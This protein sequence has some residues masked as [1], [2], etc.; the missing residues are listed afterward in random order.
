VLSFIVPA[1]LFGIVGGVVV[2]H[3]P[4]RAVLVL[5]S[6]L[7]AL[8]CIVFLRSSESVW[9]I[10]GTNL[11]LST[12]SQFSGPAESAVVP[13]LV[14]GGQIA[15]ATALLNV[16]VILAQVAGTVVLAPLFVKTLG[17]DRLFLTTIVLFALSAAA[18]AAMPRSPRRPPGWMREH[19]E[20]RFTGLRASAVE[21]WRV[22][23]SNRSVFLAG[24]QQTVVTT[25]IVVLVSLLPNY[26]RSTLHLPTEDAVFV[27]APAAI[28]VGLGNWLVPKLA[29]RRGRSLLAGAG[30]LVFLL[31]L[32][33]LGFSV[34]VEDLAR[35]HH[36]LGPLGALAPGFFYSPGAFAGVVAMPLGFGYAIVLVAARLITYE[37]VPAQM[38]GRVFAFQ[39]VL[40]S[41]ASIVPLLLVGL[42]T[43]LI[44]PRA[45]LVALA[46]VDL[47]A[48]LY[49][50]ATLPRGAGVGPPR[51]L[52]LS[53]VQP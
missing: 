36:V 19:E 40:S 47:A 8:L 28:G 32:G 30:F 14:D 39:G 44:G 52:P 1:A 13:A 31:C 29:R 15:S 35:G 11:A 50:R 51:P 33:A 17:A 16:G 41:L 22:M 27:F 21:S 2:D 12:V 6:L 18:Y 9:V 42:L 53:R 46:A 5:S 23:R 26:T 48:L 20:P 37:H 34:Q 43:H 49:A 10:Y 4:K 45:V 25:T 3:L 38:H 7:R 24:I